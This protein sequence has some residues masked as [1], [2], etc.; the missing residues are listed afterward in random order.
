MK[1]ATSPHHYERFKFALKNITNKDVEED[2]IC[3]WKNVEEAMYQ[4]VGKENKVNTL[5]GQSPQKGTM[6]FT[7]V[8]NRKNDSI[9]S[10]MCF[11]K[12][13]HNTY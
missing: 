9:S 12:L 1:K 8:K 4:A 10:T 11:L 3:S 7:M 13:I 2:F 6:H 5:Q